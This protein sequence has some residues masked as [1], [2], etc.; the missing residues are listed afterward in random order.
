MSCRWC[1]LLLAVVIIVFTQW[2]TQFFSAMT[3]KWIV[4]VAAAVLLVHSLL[5]HKCQGLCAG[6]MMKGTGK[7]RRR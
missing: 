1:E 3:S 2:N 4:L 6:M 7:R 5:C